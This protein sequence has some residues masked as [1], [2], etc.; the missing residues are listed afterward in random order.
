MKTITFTVLTLFVTSLS[1]SQTVN[2]DSLKSNLGYGKT[3]EFIH[4][5]TRS[6]ISSYRFI[7]RT[8]KSQNPI[9]TLQV[10]NEDINDL[11]WK[12]RV[13]FNNDK[14]GIGLLSPEELLDVNGNARVKKLII[15]PVA[16][17]GRFL[18][19][20]KTVSSEHR[21]FNFGSSNDYSGYSFFNVDGTLRMD[22][23]S[24]ANTTYLGLSDENQQEF[25]K[26]S[27]SSTTGA[28]VH[29]PQANSRI[30]IGGFGDYLLADNYKF[31]VKDGNSLIE[32]NL[33]ASGNIGIGTYNPDAELT[34]KGKIHAEEVKIDLNVPA[35]YVFEKYYEGTS[36]LKSDYIMPTLKEVEDYTKKN[37][38]LPSVPSAKEMK[39]KGIKVS[40]MTNLLLQKIEELTLYT[41]AQEKRIKALEEKNKKQ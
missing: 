11:G 41:I 26:A 5:E 36:K 40:E 30:V 29:L 7:N 10:K 37:H 13:T 28:F 20:G 19:M 3:L 4:G 31:I 22:F 16:N 2:F 32:G 33:I 39:K 38:H 25:F 18:Q 24:H 21:L 34:V 9:L 35:D 17:G 15:N 8:D 6:G 12:N 1:F 23:S 14:V 27:K